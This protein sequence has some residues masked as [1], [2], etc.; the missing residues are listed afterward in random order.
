MLDIE[1]HKQSPEPDVLA[2]RHAQ[3]DNFGVAEFCSQFA[4]KNVVNRLMVQRHL[5]GKF[6]GQSFS[7][8]EEGTRVSPD[9]VAFSTKPVLPYVVVLSPRQLPD[10]CA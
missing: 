10:Q 7:V 6:H 3:L 5:F 8:A 4:E 2:D 1:D 9:T